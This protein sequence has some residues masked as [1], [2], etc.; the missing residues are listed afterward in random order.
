MLVELSHSRKNSDTKLTS[1]IKEWI[2]RNCESNVRTS[3]IAD[4]FG[5]NE[6]YLNRI[7]KRQCG[8]GLKKYIDGIRLDMIRRDL[9]IGG[10]TL[11]EISEKYGFSEYKYFLNFFKY[12]EGMSPNSYRKTYYNMHTNS[13]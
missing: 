3:E 1:E 5:Y 8:V 7:F 4:A 13:K 11:S 9:L 10:V 2:R 6:D 12:H